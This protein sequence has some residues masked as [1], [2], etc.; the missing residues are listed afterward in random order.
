MSLGEVDELRERVAVL[1]E[2]CARL[3]GLLRECIVLVRS[4]L[5]QA[6]EEGGSRAA[7]I[8]AVKVAE[9]ALRRFDDAVREN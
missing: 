3:L 2:R 4:M 8:R 6:L 9:E 5:K 7:I 1:E